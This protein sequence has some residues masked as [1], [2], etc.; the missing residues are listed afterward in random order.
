VD[1]GNP[2][3]PAAPGDQLNV[4]ALGLI[5]VD[6]GNEVRVAGKKLVTY[7]EIEKVEI[8]DAADDNV[9][10][11]VVEIGINTAQVD[12]ADLAKGPQ[13]SS[14]ETQR[15]TIRSLQVQFSEEV[16]VDTSDL[17][18]TNLGINAAN[19]TDTVVSLDAGQLS[20]LGTLLTISFEADDLDDGVYEL[21]VHS[22]VTDVDGNA[23]DGD[24]NGIAGDEHIFR[25]NKT[26]NFHQLEA[27]WNGDSGVSVFDFT[28]FSYWFGSPSEIAP[29]VRRPE[30]RWRR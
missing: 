1:G 29:P 25:G 13:P 8:D 16:S 4:Q 21:V 10:P 19:D 17:T 24:G 2:V 20:I 23:L 28:S 6:D 30:W 3:A 26:N 27:N 11:T 15:S 22:T 7:V 18:L 12:P 14:W 9:A 5:A